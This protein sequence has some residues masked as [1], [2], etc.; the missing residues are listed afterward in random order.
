MEQ[1][2]I[3]SQYFADISKIIVGSSVVGFFI[4][5]SGIIVSARV[6]DHLTYQLEI[7]QIGIYMRD[8]LIAYVI[9][10]AI[11]VIAYVFIMRNR[12]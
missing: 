4:P 5:T 9:L 11:A 1:S 8:L 12:K 7:K 10:G 2:K 3:L 6:L